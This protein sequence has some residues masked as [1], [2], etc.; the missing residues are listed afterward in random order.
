M[1][2]AIMALVF[3]IALAPGAALFAADTA[4][5]R[6]GTDNKAGSA[7][8]K[9]PP[10]LVEGEVL[11]IEQDFY[12]VKDR[13]GQEVKI[14]L[15]QRTMIAGSPKVGD[16]VIAQIEP[17]G[18]AYSIKREAGMG[19]S[20]VEPDTRSIPPA[21]RDMPGVPSTGDIRGQ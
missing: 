20:A 4:E 3:S 15:D 5:P 11:K 19:T 17:Q 14:Q 8:S 16:H 2:K 18:N 6:Q 13:R 12:L 21:M 10:P 7:E 9:M 1:N